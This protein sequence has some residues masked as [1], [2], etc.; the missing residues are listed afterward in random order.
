MKAEK[1]KKQA[2]LD[3][4]DQ[5]KTKRP[6]EACKIAGVVLSTFYWHQ[7]KD[8]VFRQKVLGKQRDH[9]TAR[10]ASAA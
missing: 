8:P 2:L 4:F 10:I 9:L 3:A 5:S 7:Y 1:N 6:T